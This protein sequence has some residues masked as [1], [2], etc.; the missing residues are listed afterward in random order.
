VGKEGRGI[1]LDVTSISHRFHFG[2]TSIP[3][4]SVRWPLLSPRAS[5]NCFPGRPSGNWRST[6]MVVRSCLGAAGTHNSC[7]RNCEGGQN[8]PT[9]LPQK[10][11][12]LSR[13]HFL[14]TKQNYRQAICLGAATRG[15]H[16]SKFRFMSMKH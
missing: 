13:F 12:W 6:K 1:S 11:Q 15:A 5:Q 9:N 3:L 7:S 14:L 4:P 16:V 8:G 10:P 2:F